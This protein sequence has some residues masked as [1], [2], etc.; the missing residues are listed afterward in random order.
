MTRPKASAA[1]DRISQETIE[2]L[3][4]RIEYRRIPGKVGPRRP[5]GPRLA[6]NNGAIARRYARPQARRQPR[7]RRAQLRERSSSSSDFVTEILG[8]H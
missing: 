3:K 8:A 1:V 5:S 2:K 7:R 6:E 4:P